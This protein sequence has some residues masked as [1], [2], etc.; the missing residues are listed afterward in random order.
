MAKAAA[1]LKRFAL[2]LQGILKNKKEKEEKEEEEV[3]RPT[4]RPRRKDPLPSQGPT[5]PRK[6]YEFGRQ[7]CSVRNEWQ[8]RLGR[9]VTGK[10]FVI[11]SAMLGLASKTLRL[12]GIAVKWHRSSKV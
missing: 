10:P 7:D 5:N 2:V 1:N 3:E 11:G 12:R 6:D 9:K 8:S 4:R